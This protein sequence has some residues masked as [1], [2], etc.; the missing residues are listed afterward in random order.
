MPN[1]PG[2]LS[3]DAILCTP[4]VIAFPIGI[5]IDQVLPF[6]ALYNITASHCFYIYKGVRAL[7][8]NRPPLPPYISRSW[9]PPSLST[10]MKS[11][12]PQSYTPSG[13]TGNVKSWILRMVFVVALA[14]TLQL[15][16]VYASPLPTNPGSGSGTPVHANSL[17]PE[18]T[19]APRHAKLAKAW[20][21]WTMLVT[22][23]TLIG[24]A[25]AKPEIARESKGKFTSVKNLILPN[26]LWSL[27]TDEV[28]LLPKLGLMNQ[29]PQEN[30]N[31]MVYAKTSMIDEMRS[32][33][34]YERAEPPSYPEEHLPLYTEQP[35]KVSHPTLFFENPEF[36]GI[37]VMRISK[38][39]INA[40]ELDAVCH[41]TTKDLLKLKASWNEWKSSIRGWD[42]RRD[43]VV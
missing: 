11:Q 3:R 16:T 42:Q 19:G 31:C 6:A 32:D 20:D 15:S 25:Y 22:G 1:Y 40:W 35:T 14:S 9:S 36:P 2:S 12:A 10:S 30:W 27:M 39:M 37:V 23:S 26:P 34:L 33:M 24:F 4:F 21:K 8:S 18:S 13:R 38:V 29:N 28:Y 7:E 17:A 43:L 41:E 5:S